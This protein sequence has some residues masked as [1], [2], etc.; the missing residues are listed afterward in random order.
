MTINLEPARSSR[1]WPFQAA[2]W[3]L[4]RVAQ[5]PPPKGRVLFETGYGS[6]GLSHI[7]TFGKVFRTTVCRRPCG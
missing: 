4:Q 2:E 7:G 6:S 1:A 5:Q 3:L